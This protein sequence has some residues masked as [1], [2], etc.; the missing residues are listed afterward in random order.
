MTPLIRQDLFGLTQVPF[1]Q[2]PAKAY[3][4]EQRQECF[5]GLLRFLEYRGFAA[6]CGEPG[7][8]KTMLMKLLC[9]SLHQPSHK[10]IYLQFSN[11][12]DTD[13]FRFLCREFGLDVPF[14]KNDL[15]K[16]L[17]EYIRNLKLKILIIFDEVQNANSKTLEAL[18]LLSCDNFD[19]KR[20]LCV[21]F[22]GTPQF[23]DQLKLK[24]NE[25][26]RQRITF[27]YKL[28]ELNQR[29]CREYL[30]HCLKEAGTHLQVFDE[31][32]I[33]LIFDVSEGRIRLIN[34]IAAN[35]M[36]EASQEEVNS[37][38]IKHV[39]KAQKNVLIPTPEFRI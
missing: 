8:G 36:M 30:E 23:F 26:L 18:R 4:D 32:A 12:S 1:I 9:E 16:Q 14:R 2:I 28:K 19:S 20:K 24:I 34:T 21:V 17:Q 11:L 10:I 29:S 37:V 31:Q 25:S 22:T 27:F 35:A 13:L 38:E 3:F 39:Q 5:D 33:K 15:I 6:V 7:T